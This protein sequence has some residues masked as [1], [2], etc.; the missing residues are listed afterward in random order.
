MIYLI[1][2]REKA[3]AQSSLKDGC[4]EGD[5]SCCPEGKE[6][7]GR[8]ERGGEGR[9]EGE[10]GKWWGRDGGERKRGLMFLYGPRSC[11]AQIPPLI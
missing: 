5:L 11:F 10:G 8:G 4:T 6:G 9:K 7:G 2:P 3:P 1:N